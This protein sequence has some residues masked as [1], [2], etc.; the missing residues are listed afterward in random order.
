[1]SRHTAHRALHQKV[2]AALDEKI[3]DGE[4]DK[5]LAERHEEVEALLREGREAKSRGAVA[6]IEP[7]H[8][9]LRR[10]RER[11]KAAE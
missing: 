5:L 1:M 2:E 4:M 8:V 10:A 11:L 7:L 6:E 9:F 3:S